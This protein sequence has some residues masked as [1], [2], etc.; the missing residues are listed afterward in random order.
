[1]QSSLH[2]QIVMLSIIINIKFYDYRILFH[3]FLAHC[4]DHDP[5]SSNSDN[6]SKEEIIETSLASSFSVWGRCVWTL[7]MINSTVRH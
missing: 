3:A 2:T 1:M 5:G 4:P 6:K 7:D